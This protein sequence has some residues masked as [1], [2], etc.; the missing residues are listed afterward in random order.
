[1]RTVAEHREAIRDLLAPLRSRAPVIET[2]GSTS[3]L[4]RV[5]ADDLRSPIDHPPFDNSQMDGYAVR[6]AEIIPD[7]AMAVSTP[8][9]AGQPV[10]VLPSSTAAPIMT[11]APVPTGADA[12]IPI[13][14]AVPDRFPTGAGEHT[15]AFRTTADAG[16]YVRRQ[17]SDLAAGELL[18]AAGT[19]LGAAQWGIIAA[20]GLSLVPLV[21]PVRVLVVSSGDELQLPGHPL[22]SG[23]VYDS[24]GISMAMALAAVGAEVQS[25]QA[26]SDDA[27]GLTRLLASSAAV[28]DLVLTTG[29]VSKGAYE[30][31]R[32]VLEPAG[33]QFGAVAMQPG[34]PQ[35][36][37]TAELVHDAGTP[38]RV[39]VIAFP[40]NPVS[41]LVSFEVF[42]APALRE[43]HRLPPR[44]IATAP[45]A[46]PIDSPPGKHQVRRGRLTAAGTV[47]LVGGP[48]SHL[49]HGYA[50]STHLVHLP[51][52]VS[53]LDAGDEVEI[54]SIE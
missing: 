16:A 41:A 40:G 25:V 43:V 39:P 31:V 17:G 21:Q 7:H 13:E 45:L 3:L 53:R 44:A 14:G 34:G 47:E 51:L 38:R 8:I 12:V 23:Q 6:S 30:V 49:L 32:E 22:A 19:R 33:V 20:S 50:S 24:N 5:L 37:G 26:V 18:L 27:G 15:V 29:G 46:S 10:S 42:L 35:G 52:G 11:G 36:W 28:A 2:V 48:S 9:A 4:G 54:W 1:M